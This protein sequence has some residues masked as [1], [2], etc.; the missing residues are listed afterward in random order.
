MWVTLEVYCLYEL[1]FKRRRYLLE[2]TSSGLL[3]KRFIFRVDQFLV[4]TFVCPTL[5]I[6]FGVIP[7]TLYTNKSYIIICTAPNLLIHVD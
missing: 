2:G 1:L 5:S 7:Y 4:L 6:G 3:R